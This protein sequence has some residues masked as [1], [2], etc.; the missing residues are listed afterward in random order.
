MSVTVAIILFIALALF[1]HQLTRIVVD[2]IADAERTLLDAQNIALLDIIN[3]FAN[4]WRGWRSIN[5]LPIAQDEEIEWDIRCVV[6][7]QDAEHA[8]DQGIQLTNLAHIREGD[9][10]NPRYLTP[11]WRSLMDAPVFDS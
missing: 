11:V 1:L 7:W 8:S 9:F 6:V 4:N 3:T 5:N 2:R 10:E